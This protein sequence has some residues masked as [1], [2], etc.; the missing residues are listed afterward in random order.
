M[1]SRS[2][3]HL[4]SGGCDSRMIVTWAREDVIH[5]VMVTLARENVIHEVMVTWARED[6]TMCTNYPI[7]RASLMYD[8][9][10]S[11]S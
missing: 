7:H 1:D 9:V 4:G 6:G 2:D 8:L 5:E 10:N 3:R 11:I